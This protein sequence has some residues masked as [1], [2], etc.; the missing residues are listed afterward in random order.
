MKNER[1]KSSIL[2]IE[3][4]RTDYDKICEKLNSASYQ[5]IPSSSEFQKM[6]NSMSNKKNNTI[7]D[8]IKS[9]ISSNYQ[10]LRAIICDLNLIGDGEKG[11]KVIEYI[12]DMQVDL[13]PEFTRFIPIIIYTAHSVSLAGKGILRGGSLYIDK[14]ADE[15][16][17]CFADVVKK[18][19]INFSFLC[20]KLILKRF[21]KVGLTFTGVNDTDKTYPILHRPFIEEIANKL[22][23]KYGV[24]SVFYDNFH[25]GKINGLK[26]D[27][28]LSSFYKEQC[29]YVIV[30][31]SADYSTVDKPW[32]GI[33]WGAVKE[34]AKDH[35]EKIILVKLEDFDA[36]NI[37]G[38]GTWSIFEDV[39]DNCSKFRVNLSQKEKDKLTKKLIED[40]LF[41]KIK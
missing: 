13:Y 14:E 10:N 4:E 17:N 34:Y 41:K 5:I 26:A 6:K 7:F 40:V 31:L 27:K 20:D 1:I 12:R 36:S 21:Y 25:K 30:F 23:F 32:T 28:K 35:A 37:K 8:Y 2:V 33:E 22:V 18:H 16:V 11:G 3:D 24:D 15:S 39:T 29:D 9:E 38:L 19:V